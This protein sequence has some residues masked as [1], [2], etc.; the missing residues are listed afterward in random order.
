MKPSWWLV[1]LISFMVSSL[2]LAGFVIARLWITLNATTE[3]ITAEISSD[4]PLLA[5]TGAVLDLDS[6]PEGNEDLLDT[7]DVDDV[8]SGWLAFE[9]RAL[10][11]AFRYPADWQI[12]EGTTP[13]SDYI[14][15]ADFVSKPQDALADTVPGHKL[16]MVVLT[17]PSELTLKQWM[18]QNDEEYLDQAGTIEDL[19]VDGFP[20]K[21]DYQ[22]LGYSTF[23]TVYIPLGDGTDRVIAL[24]LYGPETTFAELRPLLQSILDTIEI[25][26]A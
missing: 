20:A 23:V 1:I 10:P 14:Q 13:L 9:S 21:L 12:W 16:E 22:V 26:N 17:Q 4:V 7:T 6:I 25:S 5:E 18:I 8:T 11:I 15:I 24:S 19:M 2:I 3:A